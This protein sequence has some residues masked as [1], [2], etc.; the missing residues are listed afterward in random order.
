MLTFEQH[1]ENK[2]RKSHENGVFANLQ[3]DGV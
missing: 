1:Q 2:I 3:R